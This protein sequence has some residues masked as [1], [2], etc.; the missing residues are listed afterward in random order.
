MG[1]AMRGAFYHRPSM[2]VRDD[3]FVTAA[4]GLSCK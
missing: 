2:F 4:A 3:L 1:L